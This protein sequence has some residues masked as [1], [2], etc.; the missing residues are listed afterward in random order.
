MNI[1][2]MILHY[3]N[4]AIM[5]LHYDNIVIMPLLVSL[6]GILEQQAKIRNLKMKFQII[7]EREPTASTPALYVTEVIAYV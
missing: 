7:E 2:I 5:I 6:I 3:Y 1:A 4:I